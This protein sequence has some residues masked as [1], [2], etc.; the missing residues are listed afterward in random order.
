MSTKL[1]TRDTL[2]QP[3]QAMA[4]NT[5][6]AGESMS[7][8]N[9]EDK[10]QTKDTKAKAKESPGDK[11]CKKVSNV[12]P[13]KARKR[14][15]T[16]CLTCRRRRIKCGE[17]R[18][19]CNNC[20]KS[21]RNCEGYTPRVIFKDPLGA[22]RS[23]IRDT[24]SR[25]QPI[26][27]YD[28]AEGYHRPLQPRNAGQMP[29]PVI[30]P[31]PTQQEHQVGTGTK[32][33]GTVPAYH[34][35]PYDTSVY[36]TNDLPANLYFVN[37]HAKYF[38]SDT[39]KSRA[40]DQRGSTPTVRTLTCREHEPYLYWPSHVP[41]AVQ[42]CYESVKAF[43]TADYAPPDQ[44]GPQGSGHLHGNI[45]TSQL[46]PQHDDTTPPR[47]KANR[48]D[49]TVPAH[50]DPSLE[51]TEDD[52]LDVLS[53]EEEED[54][55]HSM[56]DATTSNLGLML[57]LSATQTNGGVRSFT[58]FLNEPNVL[59]S[60]RPPYS[61]SPLMDPQT[62]R[63][64]CHFVTATA[65]TLSLHNRHPVNPSVMFTGAP[66]P[67]FQ[68]SLFTY[69]LP[70][71]A[72]SNQALL[73]SQLALA[74]LH[75]A[76]LQQTSATPSLKH[77]HYA[78]RRVAKAVGHPTKRREIATLAATLLLGFFE[79][80]TA[81]HNKW[82]SHLAGARELI[83]EIDFAGMTKRINAYKAE[84]NM[85]RKGGMYDYGH[86]QHY[87]DQR[88][89]SF[90][91]LRTD[92]ELDEDLISI[93][94]GYRT[95]YDE[96]GHVTDLNE[97]P[98]HYHVPLTPQDVEKFEIQCDLFWWYAKQDM[99]QSLISG[100]RL[101]WSHCP[102]RAPAG[103]L[104]AVYGSMDHVILVFARLT[105]FAARDLARKIKAQKKAEEDKKRLVAQDSSARGPS[106]SSQPSLNNQQ[107][108][109]R[110]PPMYGMMPAPGRIHLPSAFDQS[111][112]DHI[113]EANK[114]IV[115]DAELE[116]ATY[117]AEREWRDIFDALDILEQAFGPDYQPLSPNHMTP[118]ST[119]FGPAL[120]YRTY[121]IACT[122]SLF[123]TARMFATRVAPSMPPAAMAAA[124]VAA[125]KT[126]HWANNIGRICAGLQPV[127][128]TAPLN[129]SHGAA[130]M[131]SCMGLFHA[132]IQF[133]DAAQRG[134][135]ITKLRNVARLTGWQTSALIASGCE[136]AWIAAAD[137]GKGPPYTRTMNAMAKDDRVS[138]RSRDADLGPPKDNND[139]RF[140]P[141]NPGT[142]VY[143]AMGILSA[144]EDMKQLK[145]D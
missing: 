83:L 137:M 101:L 134:W 119:P 3:R 140:V 94:M 126:A 23:T 117:A 77:Y 139:R 64:F 11:P 145:L 93:L 124:G 78:L 111:R 1:E 131:D 76:K 22:G 84:T 2:A 32:P 109:H 89:M 98:S 25:L 141:V 81:E 69:T 132:G 45:A 9:Q 129:P 80:T 92:K 38:S 52:D 61:A 127:S 29:L 51:D 57:A 88:R 66:V 96:Y 104:D 59:S 39:S 68:R 30:A 108:S 20:V 121:S 17:E 36:T 24:G 5:M 118:L 99:Y 87:G 122:W 26:T 21:K 67:A 86:N 85:I 56:S 40:I 28:V 107:S 46:D 16:G 12:N 60:Y 113:T 72:L 10:S 43:S 62:A 138:G 71:M 14:T 13:A 112:Q 120:Y 18:P 31:H 41:P 4:N 125:P 91:I 123:Y 37:G 103:R 114:I 143:W 65:P 70:M 136:R 74:S 35:R 49:P 63:I 47:R 144:E 54:Q 58:G 142:R 27:S 102:P 128:T 48:H 53:D 75:I 73:H 106:Q 6:A 55:D 133:R 82:N 130:L 115:K 110:P 34:D 116:T 33:F 19:T 100:N 42:G 90:D 97:P 44:A 105:D 79:V 50:Y 15:K 135:T 7:K 8:E 95:R